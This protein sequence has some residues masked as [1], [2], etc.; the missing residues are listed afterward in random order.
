MPHHSYRDCIYVGENS[1][2]VGNK[3]IEYAWEMDL[4]VGGTMTHTLKR[5]I[6]L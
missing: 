3:Y 4:N 1:L 6:K 2:A 5:V